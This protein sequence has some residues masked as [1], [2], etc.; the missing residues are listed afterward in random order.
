MRFSLPVLPATLLLL[1]ACGSSPAEP[2]DA[3]LDPIVDAEG[4]ESDAA[5]D[6]GDD[7]QIADT[8]LPDATADS[9]PEV[10]PEARDDGE[11]CVSGIQC[12][13]GVCLGPYDGFPDGYCSGEACEARRDCTGN[14]ACLRGEFNGNLCVDLCNN[15]SDC[16]EGYRCI[17]V[18]NAAY[19]Y[20]DEAGAA[21]GASCASELLGESIGSPFA[22]GRD[23]TGREVTFEI[24]EGATGFLFIAW[25]KSRRLYPADF[26]FPGG[27]TVSLSNYGLYN[28]TPLSFETLAPVMFPGGPQY[29]E[30]IEPGEVSV[31][32]GYEGSDDESFCWVMLPNFAPLDIV[33]DDIELD[34]NIYLV[35]IPGLNADTAANDEDFQGVIAELQRVYAQAGIAVGRV[36]FLDVEGEVADRFTVIREQSEVYELVKLSR[37]PGPDLADLLSV[38]VFFIRGF[39]GTEMGGTLGISSGIPGAGGLHGSASSGLVFSSS[40][41]GSR[42]GNRYV[43]QTLAHEIGHYLGLFHTTEVRN[44]G[45]DQLDDTP[46]C[47][48]IGNGDPSCPDGTNLMF[49]IAN[50]RENALL[51]TGQALILRAN[52]LTHSADE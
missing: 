37:Q 4:T 6:V 44:L 49:P 38:N 45:R 15:E 35:G 36:R 21:L 43:G 20:P 10:T 47:P 1:A 7:T 27:E 17:P 11:P 52:P 18:G 9:G 5:G 24:P 50:W 32:V 51:S 8:N 3:G 22:S 29:R 31:R 2:A 25:D 14:A 16:R 33:G 40:S 30:L 34:L 12:A 39:A 19:C 41:L 13:G 48:E 28:Y 46:T 26:T 42:D 23:L